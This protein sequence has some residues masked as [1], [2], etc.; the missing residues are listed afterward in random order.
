MVLPLKSGV[1]AEPVLVGREHEL[2]ELQV[3]LNSAVESKGNT[4]FVSG[5]AGSGKT[6]LITE[7]LGCLKEDAIVLSAWCLSDVAIPYFPFME[8]FN[9]YFSS[10][11]RETKPTEED[12]KTVKAWLVG[13]KHTD[14]SERLQNLTPQGWQ[15]LTIAAVGDALISFSKKK[16]VVLFIDDLHWAD[17]ASLALLHYI[18]RFV[19]SARVLVL[20]TYRIE[21]LNPDTE[22]HMHPLLETLRLMRREGLIT[23][24]ELPNLSQDNIAAMAEKMVGGCLH[25]DVAKRLTTESQGN[26]LYVVESLR[27][28]SEDGSLVPDQGCLRLSIDEISMPTKYKEIILRRVG[29]LK[30]NQRRILDLA[31]VVGEKFNVEL[32][33]AV[34]NQDSLEVLETLNSIGQSSSLVGCEGDY[35][36]FDHSKSRDAIYESISLPLRKGYHARIA[37]KL[38]AMSKDVKDL[39]VNDLAYH[40]V[41]AGISEK[42]IHYSLAAGAELLLEFSN[43]EAMKHYAYVLEVTS[44]FPEFIDKKTEALEGIGDSLSANGLF[45][46]ALKK[47]VQLNEITKPSAL[48]LRALRKAVFCCFWMNDWPNTLALAKKAQDYVQFDRLEYARLLIYKGFVI[49]RLGKTKEAF[50]DTKSALRVFEEEYSLKDMA[51]ALG[52]IIFLYMDVDR[53]EDELAAGLRSLSMYEE[54]EDLRGQMSTH[55]KFAVVFGV[56][57]FPKNAEYHGDEAIKIA[58]KIGEYK[59]VA[60][61]LSNKG[62]G[63]EHFG[64]LRG[65]V[66][67]NLKAA[68]YAEKTE[69]YYSIIGC[70]SNLV[71]EYSMLGEIEQAEKF[72]K[73][74]DIL[75]Q[76]VDSLKNVENLVKSFRYNKAFIL[77]AKGQWNEANKI[78]EEHKPVKVFGS[79]ISVQWKAHFAWA[80]G[81]QGRFDEAKKLLEE[82]NEAREKVK[83]KRKSIEHSKILSYLMARKEIGVGEKLEVRLDLVNV[84]KCPAT[85]VRVNGLFA[86]EFK[87]EALSPYCCIQNGVMEFKGKKVEPFLAELVKFR[88]QVEKS[89]V[90]TLNPEVFYI[91][92]MG[93]TKISRPEPITFVVH[94]MVNTKFGEE[95]ISVPILPDRLSTGLDKLDA[96]LY[97]GIPLNYS[98]MLAAPSIDEREIIV[99]KFLEAGVNSGETTFYLAVNVGIANVL[100]EKYPSTFYLV[101]CN[102]QADSMIQNLP[103]VFKLKGVE[104]LAAIDIALMK[105]FRLM[106]PS[107]GNPK[108]FCLEIVSDVLLQHHALIS[109][110]W[111]SSL[112]QRLKMQ[113]F[114]VLAVINQ[115]M[116]RQEEVQAMQGL[117]DGEIQ[118]SERETNNGFKK[119]LRVRRLFNQKY[120]ENDLILTGDNLE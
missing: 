97:G 10:K 57:G 81:K 75:M 87:S 49:G 93:V 77:T 52:E 84:S 41:R 17:S 64:D 90:F 76:E 89:G 105:V 63:R 6:R 51:N 83:E 103:N 91:D 14:R 15:D 18:S 46:E 58:E 73:K 66:A 72:A 45:K 43:S 32:L 114:T 109:R 26:P 22:G 35:Y 60:L 107:V 9:T 19:G 82:V 13:P 38:E 24:I 61:C 96:L 31:S 104:N 118:I 37:E 11:D 8:A 29:M 120:L 86:P 21:E 85:L 62:R 59:I 78:F 4:V 3:L 25:P 94:P 100:A 65:A 92:D 36:N 1:L 69:A 50:E 88:I 33:G 47:F 98:I 42:A 16:V 7:F 5:E 116:H 119:I 39:P 68:E 34:L 112:L 70:Y 110:K 71:R 53:V 67:F 99:K 54:L 12:E 79:A 27:M 101:V 102:P 95:I 56:L 55:S 44:K 115:Y 23:E 108:R 20:A 111:L 28:L 74:L 30:P 48:K 2:E 113:G 117:F 106:K 80:L 40:Y